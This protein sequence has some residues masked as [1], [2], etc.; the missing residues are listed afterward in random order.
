MP[1]GRIIKTQNS[2]FFVK[3]G[4]KLISCKLRGKLK[5]ERVNVYTGDYVNFQML[6]EDT[7]VIEQLLPR[8]NLLHRPAIA[9]IDQVV[10]VFSYSAPSPHPVLIDRFLVMAEWSKIPDVVLCFN[11]ADLKS[12]SNTDNTLLLYKEMGYTVIETSAYTDEG[13]TDLKNLLGNKVSVFAGPSG[14]GKSSLLNAVDSSLSLQVGNISEKIKRGKHTTRLA[15]L[16]PFSVGGDIVDTPGFSSLELV[17]IEA[18]KLAMYF[19]EFKDYLGGCHYRACSH[20]HEPECS[21][22]LAVENGNISEQ[23]YQSYL[24]FLQEIKERKSEHIW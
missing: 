18:E 19:R 2:F 14:V 7:G 17:D 13:I 12:V 22:K 6:T 8:K 21:I 24:R 5:K 9:N 10:I 11:K 4:K 3:Q 15:Q 23:R 20:S 16:I 1:D